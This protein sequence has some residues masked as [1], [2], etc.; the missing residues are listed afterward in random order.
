ML[1]CSFGHSPEN[2]SSSPWRGGE[3]RQ[4]NKEKSS[5]DRSSLI[6]ASSTPTPARYFLTGNEESGNDPLWVREK[7]HKKAAALV[8][9]PFHRIRSPSNQSNYLWSLRRFSQ[10]GVCSSGIKSSPSRRGIFS[11]VFMGGD[12]SRGEYYLQCMLRSVAQFT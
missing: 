9:D 4:R 11:V 7:G 1:L 2:P 8:A 3:Y 6:P 12:E 5:G 10:E